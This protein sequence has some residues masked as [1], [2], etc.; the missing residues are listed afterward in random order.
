MAKQT[1][2][3]A[4]LTIAEVPLL[5]LLSQAKN[6]V[7]LMTIENIESLN[8]ALANGRGV[9]ITVLH[10]SNFELIP[11]SLFVHG[12]D[13]TSIYKRID[14][15][16]ITSLLASYREQA[17]LKGI[18]IMSTNFF[19]KTIDLLQ[20]NSIVCV[21]I[22]TGALEAGKKKR[23]ISIEGGLFPLNI[24]WLKMAQRAKTIILPYFMYRTSK[25]FN[26]YFTKPIDLLDNPSEETAMQSLLSAYQGYFHNHADEWLLLL[27][28]KE[29]DTLLRYRHEQEA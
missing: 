1:I 2:S 21:V 29:V 19:A 28:T 23:D 26:F 27:D 12:Y 18:D 15:S 9:L 6:L 10:A 11:R 4:A 16:P 22:D 14:T 5:P 24:S 17:G 13:S 25:G 7:P 8:A 3:K 20:K